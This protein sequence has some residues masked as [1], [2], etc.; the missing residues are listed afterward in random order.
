MIALN[1]NN[2]SFRDHLESEFASSYSIDMSEFL[3]DGQYIP[4]F[5]NQLEKVTNDYEVQLPNFPIQVELFKH[6]IYRQIELD[7]NVLLAC[8]P[9]Y[10]DS[11]L[12]TI[13]S[14][15]KDGNMVEINAWELPKDRVT[16]VL[17]IDETPAGL[18]LDNSIVSK[19]MPSIQS[20]TAACEI[21][22]RAV[23][24]FTTDKGE[25]MANWPPEYYTQTWY[26]YNDNCTSWNGRQT[27]YFAS[28]YDDCTDT[29]EWSP[30]MTSDASTSEHQLAGLGHIC[31]VGTNTIPRY[32]FR[33]EL[34]ERDLDEPLGDDD[35]LDRFIVD[36]HDT[37]PENDG[38][39]NLDTEYSV[40]WTVN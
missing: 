9:V 32:F 29:T 21:R 12:T 38:T 10:D 24:W 13:H 27:K 14:F 39:Y 7:E 36:I 18:V 5:I 25:P 15:D 3:M 6:P 26:C 16:L 40:A 35:F 20:D 17:R 2:K 30:A 8:A 31:W 1:L 19:T 23:Q 4:D 33:V 37:Y 28:G 11:L 22:L 34:W